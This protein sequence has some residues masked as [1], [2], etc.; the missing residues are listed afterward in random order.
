[1]ND[2]RPDCL[3]WLIAGF[4][5]C[6]FLS[7][8]AQAQNTRPPDDNR[9]IQSLLNEVRLLRQTLQRTGLNAY[10]SQIILDRLRARH[11]QVERLTRMLEEVRNEIEKTEATIPRFVERGKVM[12]KLIEQEADAKRR[13]ELEFEQKEVTG[14]AEQ[15]K[16]SLE[17]LREREAQLSAQVR[18][19]Q[20]KLSDLEGRLDALEREIENEIERQRTEDKASDGKK[21]L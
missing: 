2:L 11:E 4:L 21:Q 8:S 13:V 16:I 3:R 14:A 12:E 6:F 17:R 5:L 7:A 10:R 20:A 19:E 18:T 9:T 1:M 15:Y